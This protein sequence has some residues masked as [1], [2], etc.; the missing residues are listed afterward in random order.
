M[1]PVLSCKSIRGL[2]CTRSASAT[3]ADVG[4][5]K[6]VVSKCQ[7]GCR[8]YQLVVV[9]LFLHNCLVGN[10]EVACNDEVARERSR[11]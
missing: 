9:F 5:R 7:H 10:N 1:H 6:C 2:D 8:T 11:S 4:C 3:T